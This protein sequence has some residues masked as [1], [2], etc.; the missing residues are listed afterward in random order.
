MMGNTVQ[1]YAVVDSDG[2]ILNIIL[3]DG[4]NTYTTT[5]K[6][7]VTNNNPDAQIGGTYKDNVFIPAPLIDETM[8]Q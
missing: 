2:T 7:V 6:L 3:W 8:E 4:R 5:F 1:R